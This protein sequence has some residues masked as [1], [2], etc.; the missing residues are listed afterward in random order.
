MHRDRLC[1][2]GLPPKSTI[3]YLQIK[4]GR[5]KRVKPNTRQQ[6]LTERIAECPRY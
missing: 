5:V 1:Y 4:L 2:C 3:V 6:P